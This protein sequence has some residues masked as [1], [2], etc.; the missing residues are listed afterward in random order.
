MENKFKLVEF[1]EVEHL[2]KTKCCE[3]LFE[4]QPQKRTIIYKIYDPYDKGGYHGGKLYESNAYYDKYIK[5]VQL[6]THYFYILTINGNVMQVDM[7]ELCDVANGIYFISGY[8]FNNYKTLVSCGGS[9]YHRM[10][11]K[12]RDFPKLLSMFWQSTFLHYN[13]NHGF[14][15]NKVKIWPPYV[16]YEH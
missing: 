9:P 4:C 13:P 14:L 2:N 12:E 8:N 10:P 5:S 3:Y 11:F 16:P 1:K 7:G 15:G 6:D